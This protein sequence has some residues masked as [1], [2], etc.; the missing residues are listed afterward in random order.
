MEQKEIAKL[1]DYYKTESL[2]K[3]NFLNFKQ[4]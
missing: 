4:S 1:F 2:F 3:R